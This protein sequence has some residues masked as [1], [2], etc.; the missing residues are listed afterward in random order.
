MKQYDRQNHSSEK[1]V[2]ELC[3]RVSLRRRIPNLRLHPK[4][5]QFSILTFYFYQYSI[6]ITT[7]NRNQHRKIGLQD[8]VVYFYPQLFMIPLRVNKGKQTKFRLRYCIEHFRSFRAILKM[9]S[10]SYL[11]KLVFPRSLWINH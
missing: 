10:F 11:P 5:I 8:F 9:S 3:I 4:N 6:C 1:I 2:R 7:L